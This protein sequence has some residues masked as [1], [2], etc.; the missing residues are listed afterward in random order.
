MKLEPMTWRKK[1]YHTE[2]QAIPKL[3]EWQNYS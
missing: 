3:V 2:W 1:H